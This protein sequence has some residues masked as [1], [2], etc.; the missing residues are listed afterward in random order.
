MRYGDEF[1]EALKAFSDLDD[2]GR[3]FALWRHMRIDFSDQE[4]KFFFRFDFLIETNLGQAEAALAQ[5]EMK[6]ATA[7]A[8]VKRRGDALFAPI[9][10]RIWVDEDGFEAPDDFVFSFLDLPYDKHGRDPRYVDTNLKTARLHAL[11]TAA[12]DAFA[13][14]DVRCGRMREAAMGKILARTSLSEA[15][16]AALA[17]ARIEDEI[18]HAQLRARIQSLSGGEAILERRQLESEQAINAG[19]YQGIQA[20]SIKV[21]VA[22]VVLLSASPYPLSGGN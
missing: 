22:G 13:N 10:D 18:R 6:T 4:P 5:Y 8:A 20:P 14:W 11:M 1:I 17:R 7:C 2:R 3:S 16:K 15:K 12:P 9:I 19:L 21:D